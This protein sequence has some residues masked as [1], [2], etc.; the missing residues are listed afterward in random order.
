MEKK[1]LYYLHGGANMMNKWSEGLIKKTREIAGDGCMLKSL[2]GEYG[3]YFSTGKGSIEIRGVDDSSFMPAPT[4]E[5]IAT[6]SD[7]EDL[8]AA[9]W[10]ID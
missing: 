9:G 10:V 4:K 7:I 3:F 5:V 8:I 1:R 2:K 6:F